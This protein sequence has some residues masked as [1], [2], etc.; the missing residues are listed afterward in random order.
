MT[1]T[2]ILQIISETASKHNL[3]RE[4]KWQVFCNVCDNALHSGVITKSQHTRWTNI[5]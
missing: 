1:K 4:E 2:K 3:S 5:F